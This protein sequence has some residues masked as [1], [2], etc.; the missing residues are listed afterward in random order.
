MILRLSI[1]PS[2]MLV[3]SG[4]KY[5]IV[6]AFSRDPPKRPFHYMLS[7][8]GSHGSAKK[9]SSL[10][11]RIQRIRLR[12]LKKY[13][14]MEL[15]ENELLKNDLGPFKIRENGKGESWT[16][17][18]IDLSAYGFLSPSFLKTKTIGIKYGSH[19]PGL[20]ICDDLEDI[21]LSQVSGDADKMYRKIQ[22]DHTC[23]AQMRKTQ[24]F[25]VGNLIHEE[26]LSLRLKKNLVDKGTEEFHQDSTA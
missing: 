11:W 5:V 22:S 14:H 1:K 2:L 15:E 9:N 18:D 16:S 12:V 25:F 24:F 7:L 21:R 26:S 10:L 6:S 8:M 3:K 4:L 19:R 20:I 17:T 23:R 13:S